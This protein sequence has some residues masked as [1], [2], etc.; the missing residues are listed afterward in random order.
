MTPEEFR[1]A[2]HELVDLVA[3]YRAGIAARPVMARVKPGDIV[4]SLPSTA[5]E[6]PEP[7]AAVRADLARLM[8]PGLTHWQHP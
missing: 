3:D 7:L 4:A 6:K 2:G 1:K 8:E 5:P